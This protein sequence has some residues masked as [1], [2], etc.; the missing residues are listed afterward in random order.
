MKITRIETFCDRFVGFVRV[1]AED[2]VQGWGQSLA[3]QRRHHRPWSCIGR[4]RPGRSDVKRDDIGALSLQSRSASTNFPA[5]YLCRAHGRSRHR[6]VGPSRQAGGQE[7]LRAA[8]GTAAASP[9]LCVVD[10]ARH[11]RPTAR[12][13]AC[14]ACATRSASTRSSSASAP[15]A[16]MTS[17]NGPA[18]RKQIV[19]AMRKALG[20]EVA[21]LVD[22]NSG[23]SPKRAIE[24]GRL[25]EDNGISHFEEPCPY[26]ELEQTKEV[27]DAL[28][29]DV[30]GGEQDC[31]LPDVATDDRDARRRHRPARRLLR[32]RPHANAAGGGHGAAGR[33]AV[34]AAQRQ[35]SIGDPVHHASARRDPNA[36]KYLEL[37]IEG[38]DYYPWQEGLFRAIA[39]RVDDGMVIIPSEPGWGVEIDPAWLER[40]RYQITRGGTDRASGMSARC[41]NGHLPA[42]TINREQDDGFRARRSP[43]EGGHR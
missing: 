17:T 6:S 29:I 19:P 9:R 16:G 24:V 22:A 28:D 34:H 39:L 20:D 1:T 11:H 13:S 30:T 35:P 43:A 15:N 10:E 23:F 31:M 38:P 18:A 41:D 12:P 37:S 7:R 27:R 32:G 8:R 2:G 3:L 26:W 33:A 21:L 4:W 5:R 40:S 42:T 25:L 14:S 36:G